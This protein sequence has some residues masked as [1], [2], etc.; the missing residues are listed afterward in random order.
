MKRFFLCALWFALSG[1]SALAA[2]GP[3]VPDRNVNP[4]AQAATD[5]GNRK[6]LFIDKRFIA[7]SEGVELRLNQAQ[8]L[9]LIQDENGNPSSES[10]HTS[11]VIE[12]Q[13][14]IRLYIGA[15]DLTALESDDG[16][17]FRRTGIT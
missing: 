1:S 12:D 10:G 16:I 9:G 13:G 6:Q 17:R 11:R 14:K 4:D 7:S 15:G 8:K 2:D 5:I 3:L